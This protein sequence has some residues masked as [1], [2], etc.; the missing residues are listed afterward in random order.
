M[1]DVHEKIKPIKKIEEAT[2]LIVED[3]AQVLAV[4]VK[5]L[6]RLGVGRVATAA[7]GIEA[8][9]RLV[10]CNFAIDLI[11]CDWNMPKLSGIDL[12]KRL[13]AERHE[14]P[15]LMLT[16]RG[17]MA[18]IL[19]AKRAGATAYAAKPYSPRHLAEKVRLLIEVGTLDDDGDAEAGSCERPPAD[20]AE[21]ASN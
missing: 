21:A 1:L 10:E 8:W 19:L 18:S 15:F 14:V 5:V 3:D 6:N 13:R 7:E 16:G 12:L 4:I 11:V 9:R 2:V 17:D 20:G